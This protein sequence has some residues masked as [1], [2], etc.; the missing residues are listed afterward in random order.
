MY[1]LW[2]A[3]DSEVLDFKGKLCRVPSLQPPPLEVSIMSSQ[4]SQTNLYVPGAL[5]VGPGVKATLSWGSS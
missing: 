1:T 5:L 4:F 3:L 2:S